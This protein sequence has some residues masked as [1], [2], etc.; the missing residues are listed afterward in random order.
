LTHPISGMTRLVGTCPWPFQNRAV[1]NQSFLVLFFK[2]ELLL[3]LKEVFSSLK[4]VAP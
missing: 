3:A 1:Q 4:G 2:Q